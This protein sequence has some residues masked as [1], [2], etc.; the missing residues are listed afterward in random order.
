MAQALK[1]RVRIGAGGRVEIGRSELPEGSFAEVIVVLDDEPV[2]GSAVS[3]PRPLSSFLGA[4]RGQF[5]SADEADAY[6][7]QLR[8]EWDGRP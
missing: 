5:K 2:P 3:P 1:Q 6:L 8:D 7:R 4:C